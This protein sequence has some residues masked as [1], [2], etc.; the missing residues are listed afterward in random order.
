MKN[1]I[2]APK[3]AIGTSSHIFTEDFGD[4]QSSH[5]DAPPVQMVEAPALPGPTSEEA[6]AQARAEGYREGYQAGQSEISVQLEQHAH[7]A[8][9]RIS[10]IQQNTTQFRQAEIEKGVEIIAR[11][12]VSYLNALLPSINFTNS[13]DEIAKLLSAVMND[14]TP[15]T[16]ISASVAPQIFRQVQD[17]IQKIHG[18]ITVISDDTVPVGDA[19]ISWDG[20]IA[21]RDVSTIISCINEIL[22][23]HKIRRV[24]EIAEIN[25][26]LASASELYFDT[27]PEAENEDA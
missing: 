16:A 3:S 27:G 18:D 24:D 17:N 5:F 25:P 23:R 1:D 8:L 10:E 15:G 14:L 11:L 19:K 13:A 2:F 9:Q 7:D 20:G 21:K 26:S 12:T 4:R 6:L 22:D